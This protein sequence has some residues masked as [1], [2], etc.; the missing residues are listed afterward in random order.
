VRNIYLTEA[1]YNIYGSIYS[2][3]SCDDKTYF[4]LTG[5]KGKEGVPGVQKRVPLL[6]WRLEPGSGVEVFFSGK[7]VFFLTTLV[8]S[9]HAHPNNRLT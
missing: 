2:V 3:K 7:I 9:D 1:L 8:S 4:K 6:A 5:E